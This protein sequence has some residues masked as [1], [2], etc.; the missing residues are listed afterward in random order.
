M[1]V[2]VPKTWMPAAA[3]RRIHVH[4]TAGGHRA[5]ATD[6]GAY[7]VLIEGDGKLVRGDKSIAANAPGSGMSP[8]SHTLGANTGAI[9]VSMCGMVGSRERP[10]NPGPAPLTEVQWQAMVAVLAQLAERYQIPVTPQTVLTHAE[11]QPNLGIVQR[12]KWDITVLPFDPGTVGHGPVGDRLRREVA[13]ALDTLRPPPPGP[14]EL[15]DALRLPRFRVQGVAPSTLN[16]RSAPDGA[17]VGALPEGTRVERLAMAGGW[18]Q[19]RT[20]RG[21]VGWVWHSF[22]T[23]LG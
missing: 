15:P 16:F 8:A 14:A 2:T 3:M 21:H 10:F 4:W 17:V 12:S 11:V 13:A 1:A 6:R 9:G 22:L 7:H 5:N 19:V 23:A 18:W 20:P